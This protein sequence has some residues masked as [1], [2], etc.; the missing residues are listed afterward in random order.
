MPTAVRY[1]RDT[2]PENFPEIKTLEKTA[3]KI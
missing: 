1:A 2:H 3:E